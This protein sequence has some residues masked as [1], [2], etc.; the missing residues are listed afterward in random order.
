[1]GQVLFFVTSAIVIGRGGTAVATIWWPLNRLISRTWIH[2]IPWVITLVFLFSTCCQ[3]CAYCDNAITLIKPILCK[4]INCIILLYNSRSI[5]TWVFSLVA[6]EALTV[7]LHVTITYPTE[8]TLNAVAAINVHERLCL[9]FN[10]IVKRCC[11]FQV[12]NQ[13]SLITV[14][15]FLAH[16]LPLISITLLKGVCDLMHK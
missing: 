8:L 14:S 5:G 3:G 11:L 15:H 12:S 2:Y 1:M 9:R 4:L 7:L 10:Y 6:I 16:F 13:T